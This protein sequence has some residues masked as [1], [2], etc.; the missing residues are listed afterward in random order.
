V[1]SPLVLVLGGTRSGKSRF[2]LKRAA[3]L[4]ADGPATYLGT[5]RPGDPELD[6]RIRGHR[7]ERPTAWATIEVGD[8]LAGAIRSVDAEG[9]VLLDGLTLWLSAIAG[10]VPADVDAILDGPF[11]SALEAIEARTG[12]TVV[13]SDEIGL[14]MVPMDGV[15]RRF[16]DL[17]GI[18]H[19]RLAARADEVYLVV[20]GIPMTMRG[21]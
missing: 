2:G 4:T 1:S 12:P 15:A 16:G 5:A 3:E 6:E 9:T 10:D 14:G 13:V 20:A 11:A 21:R 8:D 17:L 18:A 7:R 19:Q